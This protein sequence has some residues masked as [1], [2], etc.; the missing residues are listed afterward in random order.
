MNLDEIGIIAR[1]VY[2]GLSFADSRDRIIVDLDEG[3]VTVKYIS[4]GV[5]IRD[6]AA[7][8]FSTF[9]IDD[10]STW[11]DDFTFVPERF[12][13]LGFGREFMLKREE[14]LRRIGCKRLEVKPV[15]QKRDFCI[16]FGYI[17]D[18][19]SGLFYKDL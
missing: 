15:L 14:L 18:P 13:D 11:G 4:A 16:H 12:Q 10:L 6:E 1:E 17:E 8:S 19:S 3:E 7:Y 9:D 2:S 5:V